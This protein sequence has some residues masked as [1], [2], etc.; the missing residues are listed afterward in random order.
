RKHSV[1]LERNHLHS[2]KIRRCLAPWGFNSPS[3]HQHKSRVG[4]GLQHIRDSGNPGQEK[5]RNWRCDA[6]VTGMRRTQANSNHNLTELSQLGSPDPAK[7]FES[8]EVIERSPP[9]TAQLPYG[10]D[11][12]F[13]TLGGRSEARWRLVRQLQS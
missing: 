10:L 13:V 5:A 2:L 11:L 6:V 3:R 8:V 7:C 1:V 4:R 9:Q 12:D